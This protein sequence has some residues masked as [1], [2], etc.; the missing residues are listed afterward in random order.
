MAAERERAQGEQENDVKRE[1]GMP[2]GGKGRR[3]EV[4]RS[5]VYPVSEIDEAPA[6]AVIRGQMEWGQGERGAA[7]YE[8]HGDSE[9]MAF[10]EAVER[11]GYSIEPVKKEKDEDKGRSA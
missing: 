7:G 6:D 8:D 1:S 10:W 4:G 9:D 3:E 5:G 2:G 11:G